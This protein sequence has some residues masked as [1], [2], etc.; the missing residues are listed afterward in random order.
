[1]AQYELNLRDYLRV[2]RKGKLIV[3]FAAAS[4]GFFSFLFATLQKPIPLYRAASSVKVE[5]VLPQQ[6]CT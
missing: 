2:L 1:M 4:L 5:K 3:I 6:A